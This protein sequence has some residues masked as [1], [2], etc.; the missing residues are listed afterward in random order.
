MD[1]R[2]ELLS[3]VASLYYLLNQSQMQIAERLELS[4]STVSRLIREAR[5]RG[6]VEITVHMPIPREI[7][8]EQALIERFGLKDAYVLR[9]QPNK[10]HEE[11]LRALGHLAAS[12]V[13]R[14]IETSREEMNIGVAWGTGV[15]AAVE[16]LPDQ[17]DRHMDVVQLMGGTGTLMVDSP[18]LARMVAR[19]LGGRHYDLNAPVLVE[20]SLVRDILV[21]EP[22]VREGLRRARQVGLAILGIGTVLEEG[23]GFLR[24]GLLTKTD[25]DTLREQGVAGEICGRFIDCQGN[26]EPFDINQ[27]VIGLELNDLRN[28]PHSIAIA[29]GLYKVPSILSVLHGGYIQALATDDE[30]ARAVLDAPS[31]GA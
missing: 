11:R 24:A 10:D 14:V 22:A 25:L 1:Q 3:T 7:Q 18:D 15:H 4:P 29:H 17:P 12:Y 8:L 19:K 26:F 13:N 27:R 2:E 6:I 21:Q 23:S 9:T 28:V 31:V 30:T 16:A 5:E 20:R